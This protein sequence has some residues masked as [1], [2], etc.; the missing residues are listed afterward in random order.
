ML[1]GKITIHDKLFQNASSSVKTI[2]SQS[3]QPLGWQFS[4][5]FYIIS[6]IDNRKSWIDKGVD[7]NFRRKL[8]A[9][10]NRI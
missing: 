4:T 8:C 9:Q 5:G 10:D 6:A 2:N 3:Q 7:E 1:L